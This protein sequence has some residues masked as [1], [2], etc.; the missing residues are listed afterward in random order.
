MQI[1]AAYDQ[2]IGGR[3]YLATTKDGLLADAAPSHVEA[4]VVGAPATPEP[5]PAGAP[6]AP[7]AQVAALEPLSGRTISDPIYLREIGDRLFDQGFDPGEPS[8]STTTEAIRG[9]ESRQGLPLTGLPTPDLLGVL[10]RTKPPSPWGAIAFG[11]RGMRFGL[12]WGKSGRREALAEARSD[13]GTS[14]CTDVVS[15]SG[16]QCGALATSS[17]SFYIAWKIDAAGARDDAIKQCETHG[18]TCEVRRAV[19]ADGSG[20]LAGRYRPGRLQKTVGGKV[21]VPN[22]QMH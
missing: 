17:K 21:A 14:D 19:C 8:S 16:T 5:K 7:A 11:H 13:C 10:R 12:V 2:I 15:F 22:P 18:A 9:F 4:E 6:A 3:V 1:P 20:R